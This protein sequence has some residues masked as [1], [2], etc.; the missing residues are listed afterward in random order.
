MIAVGSDVILALFQGNMGS[1]CH[2][3]LKEIIQNAVN[4]NS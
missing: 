2:I 4:F 1:T 3:S